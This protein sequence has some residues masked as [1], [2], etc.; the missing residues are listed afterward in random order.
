MTS[1]AQAS[2][3]KLGLPTMLSYGVGSV[4]FGISVQSL[5]AAVLQLY[6]NQVIGLPAVWVGAAI[7]ASLVVDAVLDPLI[8]RWS[9]NFRSRLGRRHPFM[10]AAAGPTAFAFFFLWNPPHGLTTGG[11]FAFMIGMLIAVRLS[12][13][14]YE[15]PSTALAP[16][17]APDYDRR[18][19]LL[20]FRYFFGIIGGAAITF[21]LYQ[22]FLRQDE[23]NPLGVLNPEGYAHFGGFAAVVM[24][25]CILLST[26]ATHGRIR[27][28]HQAPARDVPLRQAIAEIV[29]NFSNR[30]LLVLML[31]GLVGG[32]SLGLTSGLSTYFYIHLWGLKSQ[33]VSYIIA[34][35]LIASLLG[36]TLAPLMSRLMGKKRAMI[37]LFSISLVA[38]LIP[39]GFRLLGWMPP[40][41]TPLLLGLLIGDYVVTTTLGLMG[42][43]IVTSMVADVVEDNAVRTGQRSEG[44]LFAANS[45]L[46]KCT[47]GVGAFTAGALLSLV[48]FPAHAAPG[49]VDPDIMRHLALIYLPAVALLSGTSIAVLTLYRIDRATHERNLERLRDAAALAELAE[50]ELD[51]H[52]E[53]RRTT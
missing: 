42:F 39:I 46:S 23:A 11:Q 35:G 6:F 47:T 51:P 40:N 15:I 32:V 48:Q 13:S 26:A 30:S 4:A 49:S 2:E 10:Y 43:I 7:M 20:A 22:V 33:Q 24:F 52:L 19:T 21:L 44:L 34:G 36:V 50:H 37:L 9:D 1:R 41:G 8:G 14:L 31:S 27:H 17:L 18:T 25:V 38:S 12:V 53:A 5:S 29:A 3:P 45:L 28:L 16:E